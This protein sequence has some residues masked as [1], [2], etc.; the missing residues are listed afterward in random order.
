MS[1]ISKAS[2][3]RYLLGQLTEGEQ[4]QIEERL[5][6]DSEFEEEILLIEDD[7]IEQYIEGEVVDRSG[8]AK[9]MCS[10][11]QQL[12]LKVSLALRTYVVK[13]DQTHDLKSITGN[14]PFSWF[15][16]W[17]RRREPSPLM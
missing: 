11:R 6:L 1:E 8:F 17:F 13:S 16:T 3:E 12:K 7:L 15:K 10:P 2:I 5:M 9:L 4:T 14:T